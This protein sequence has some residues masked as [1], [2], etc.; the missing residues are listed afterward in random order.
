MFKGAPRSAFIKARLLRNKMTV[1]ESTLWTYL[2][3][4]R[5]EGYKFRRQHP[6]HL[7]IVDFYCHELGLVIE[8]D[9]EYH[10]TTEQ[11]E[12]DENEPNC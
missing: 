6:L 7:Y 1:A 10:E 12:E 11:Q 4:K 2:Q 8:I 9:G 3:N 5:F